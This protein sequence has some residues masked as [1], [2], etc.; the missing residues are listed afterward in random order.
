M[1]GAGLRSATSGR[2]PVEQVAEEVRP[3][4]QSYSQNRDSMGFPSERVLNNEPVQPNRSRQQ[5]F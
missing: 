2:T 5:L 3:G 1:L 4:L